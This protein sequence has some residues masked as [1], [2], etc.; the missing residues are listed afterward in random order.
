[1]KRLLII[2]ISTLNI[3]QA[4]VAIAT[5]DQL[6][7]IVSGTATAA[8]VQEESFFSKQEKAL[9]K[10][11]KQ[12]KELADNGGW[13][14]WQIG[15]KLK[16]N[17]TDARIGNL[18]RILTVTGDYPTASGVSA[19]SQIYDEALVQAVKRFQTRHGLNPDGTL[20]KSTQQ[21][22]AVPVEKRI[23]Q[24]MITLERLHNSSVLHENK[25]VLVNLPAYTLFGIEQNKEALRMRVIIGNR[26]NHTPIFDNVINNVVFNPP[27]NVPPRIARNEMLPKLR[28]DPEYFV[29]AGFT[30][31]KNGEVVDPLS[32][33]T[34]GG[35]FSFRQHSGETSALGK[36]KFNIPNSNDIYL[37]STSSPKLF[38]KEDRAM[39]HGCVRLE[40]PRDLAHFV[41]NGQNDWDSNKVDKI[42]DSS[43]QRSFGINEVPVHLVYW[44]A[45]VDDNGVVYFYGDVYNKDKSVEANLQKKSDATVIAVK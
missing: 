21:A 16:L 41:L 17:D 38:A 45:F 36:I 7:E 5:P 35:G 31:T 28:E 19:E 25:L 1:M 32:V 4:S 33:D 43:T 15:K 40:K 34:S 9:Q 30:V 11:L 3:L 42:Y 14:Q 29:N 22:L 13:S 12:Y 8:Q 23:T 39:S 44:T 2:L 18:R 10:Q 6:L 37:H 20:G 26:N 27:W 24:I